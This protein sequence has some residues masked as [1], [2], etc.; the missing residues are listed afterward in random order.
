MKY[1]QKSF[2]LFA[3]FFLAVHPVLAQVPNDFYYLDQW[4]LSFIGTPEVWEMTTGSEDLIVAVLDTGVDLDHEDL[5]DHL[6]INEKEKAG[7]GIDNDDNGY[8]DDV[9]GWDFV[10][11][12][13]TPTPDVGEG[14]DEGSV[15]H[16]TM[17]A[18]VIAA[19]TDNEKGVAGMSWNSK[20]MALRVMDN[21][22]AGLSTDV[23][24]AINYAVAEGAKIINLSFSGYDADNRLRTAVRE[25]YEAGVLVVAAVGN[26]SSGGVNTDIQPVYPACFGS[27]SSDDWVLGVA[28]TNEEDEKA[29]FSNYGSTCVDI[30]APGENFYSTYYFDE[31]WEGFDE[32]EYM[33]QWSGTSLATPV[34][35][36]AAA[37]LWSYYPS[38]T[39]GEV[40][41]ILKL[42][43]DPVVELGPIGRGDMGAG[44]V[45]VERAFEIAANFAEPVSTAAVEEVT[46]IPS[47]N[48][49]VVPSAGAPPLIRVF[50]KSGVLLTEFLAYDSAFTGGVRVAVGDV[51]GDGE[52]EIVSAPGPG[53]EPD[54][55]VFEQD[56][57]MLKGFNAFESAMTSGCYVATGDT[58]QDGK[59]EIAVTA[60]AGGSNEVRVFDEEGED[61]L[62]IPIDRYE[63]AAVRV[64]MGDTDG[65]EQDEIILSYGPGTEPWID[66]YKEDGT[67]TASFLV[68]AQTY[69]NGVYV[70]SGDINGDGLD[71]IVTGT[72]EGGG[73]H[74]QIYT[75][76]GQHLGTFFAYDEA[77]R[78]GVRVAVGNLS[79]EV[80]GTASI[81]AAAGPGGG[82]HIRV[83]NDHATLIG[84]FFTDAKEDRDGI[85]VG[86]WSY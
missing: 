28:A 46:I 77:F 68:Y 84:T 82:P 13:A 66:V 42:S 64:A 86:A 73:P 63:D 79:D 61:V 2:F 69:S 78:G 53:G 50:A 40:Q 19:V 71:E 54:I 41:T 43:V 48:I 35:S 5:E 83:F 76:A 1:F 21:Y 23:T 65:D 27:Q 47:T 67:K 30:S 62:Q 39:V 25:A 12:D 85:F 22:G 3:I 72:D 20:I 32:D 31:D 51:D 45:N 8:I 33:G 18:G 58:D 38:L 56:G 34:I 16:G 70:S 81:I 49:I 17:I 57:I 4:Y 7:D 26:L 80:G 55:R 59:E 37:L 6:W 29:I 14:F 24:E 52:D 11:E 44:R 74:V 9:Y 15:P 75:G 36:G 60:E 10:G